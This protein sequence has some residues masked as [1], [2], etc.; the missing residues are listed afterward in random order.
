MVLSA[1][2]ITFM[3][4]W[5]QTDLDYFNKHQT[6]GILI[7]VDLYVFFEISHFFLDFRNSSVAYAKMVVCIHGRPN[8]IE[9]DL[10]IL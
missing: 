1:V 3:C 8:S 9:L 7:R 6:L 2:L 5:Q 10:S 4:R